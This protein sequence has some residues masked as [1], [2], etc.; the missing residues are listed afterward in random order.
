MNRLTLFRF[1]VA[2]GIAAASGCTAPGA[3][4]DRPPISGPITVEMNPSGI[5]PLSGLI[6]FSTDRPMR[7]T[8][9][10]SDGEHDDVTVTPVDAFNT[11]HELMLLGLRPS[12][13]QRVEISLEDSA[14]Q[15][16]DAGGF[17]VRTD[18]LPHWLPPIETTISMP[19]RM[20]PGITLLPVFEDN[21][22][23]YNFVVGLDNCGDI[24]WFLYHGVD[25]LRRM[26]NGNLLTITDGIAKNHLKEFDMLGRIVRE[27]QAVGTIE[28]VPDG[29][30]PVEMDTFHHDILE[31][32]SG[33]FLA[34]SSE[35]R[36]L[37]AYRSDDMRGQEVGPYPQD[38]IADRLVEFRPD[39]GEIVRDWKMTDLLDRNRPVHGPQEFVYRFYD[40]AYERVLEQP[41]PDWTHMNGIFYDAATDSVIA[42]IRKMSSIIKLDLADNELVWI[43]GNHAGWGPGFTDLLLEPISDLTYTY[44]QHAPEITPTGTLLL[45]DNGS[46]GRAFPGTA[47]QPMAERYSRAVEFEIDETAGRVRQIWS[48]GGPG[49]EHFYS[50]FVSEA[51]RLPLTGNTLL[52]SGGQMVTKD[53]EQTNN[54]DAGRV[55]VSVK[56]VT[57]T[58][59]AEKVWEVVID[60]PMR[61]WG[62]YRVE[63]VPGL[64]P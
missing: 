6:R 52:D 25:E 23:L 60:D 10:I 26:Q 11:E 14:G 3:D 29:V 42:S 47:R 2:V 13:S 64:Y 32:P 33:N 7:A 46:Y 51:D 21:D 48:Y 53:G 17:D 43:L 56:E 1:L 50:E 34:I 35:I 45:Y 36:H 49:S 61:E 57:T 63:R 54:F 22:P 40:R 20:E 58:T 15:I 8:L 18:D 27:W 5:A 4:V 16:S 59:P 44:G 55:W 19:E 41:L 62:S 30:I 31:M 39:T 9:T 38:V 24:V 12:R 28:N 37:D